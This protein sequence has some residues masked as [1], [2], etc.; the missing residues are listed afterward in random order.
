REGIPVQGVLQTT[1][2]AS[3]STTTDALSNAMFVLGPEAGMKML[4]TVP[5]ARGLWVSG[6][7]PQRL[8]KW[9]WQECEPPIGSG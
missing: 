1:L 6:P 3:D 8:A 5:D 9:R 4:S 2:I 7:G